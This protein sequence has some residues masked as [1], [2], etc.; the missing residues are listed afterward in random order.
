MILVNVDDP[1]QTIATATSA[2]SPQIAANERKLFGRRFIDVSIVRSGCCAV[3]ISAPASREIH[4]WPTVA[5]QARSL[6]LAL[7]RGA[8]SKLRATGAPRACRNRHPCRAWRANAT[9]GQAD[10]SFRLEPPRQART[11]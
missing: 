5:A 3:R 8:G 10:H 6:P 11:R 1:F 4:G 9:F 2:M 7:L